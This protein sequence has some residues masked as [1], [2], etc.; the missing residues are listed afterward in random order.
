MFKA[1][2]THYITHLWFIKKT[3]KRSIKLKRKCHFW[4][5]K[6]QGDAVEK[7]QK[8]KASIFVYFLLTLTKVFFASFLNIQKLRIRKFQFFQRFL[9]I[10][11]DEPLSAL[12][13]HCALSFYNE[14]SLFISFQFLRLILCTWKIPGKL[15]F[16]LQRCP[17]IKGQHCT[18]TYLHSN[19]YNKTY[20]LTF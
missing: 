7:R 2:H 11:F 5:K 8:L 3:F 15:N 16:Y 20:H 19:T 1:L 10:E 17:Y 12:N 4:S 13:M 14:V 6:L 18:F 9:C